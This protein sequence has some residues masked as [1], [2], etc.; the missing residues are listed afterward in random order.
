MEKCVLFVWE[1]QLSNEKGGIKRVAGRHKE[2]EQTEEQ[3]EI[4]YLAV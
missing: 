1:T 3:T 4:I 2:C